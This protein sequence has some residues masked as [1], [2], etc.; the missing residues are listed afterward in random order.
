MAIG[1]AISVKFCHFC[2]YSALVLIRK[3]EKAVAVSGVCAGVLEESSGKI[4][5]KLLDKCSRIAKCFKFLEFSGTGKGKPPCGVFFGIDSYS[6]LGF[7]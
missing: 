5:G 2:S 6:L 3:L 4:P 7:F 1:I